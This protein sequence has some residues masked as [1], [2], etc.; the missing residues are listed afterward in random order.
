[1]QKEQE[2]KKQI[3]KSAESVKKKLKIMRDIS[4]SNDMVIESV[5]KPISEPLKKIAN[6]ND[7]QSGTETENFTPRKIKA[8]KWKFTPPK[9]IKKR[10]LSLSDS[11]DSYSDAPAN[12]Y[13]EETDEN[14]NGD[15]E[16]PDE[17][18]HNTSWSMSSE[19]FENIPFGVRRDKGKLFLG[20]SRLSV[21]ENNIL[22]AGHDY[23][24]TVGLMELLF[25]KTPNLNLITE[26][27]KNNYKSML[28]DTNVHRRDYDASKPIKSNKGIKYTQI[29][30]PLFKLSKKVECSGSENLEVQGTGLLKK[31]KQNVDYVYWDNP[32]E[33][34]ERLKLLWA[35]RDAGN[36]GVNNE[37]ISIMEELRESRII[38]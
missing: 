35:S 7:H 22:V 20:S 5:L 36:T 11:N 15:F 19:T 16:T 2:L 37:I 23:I 13:D 18:T 27:D 6:N 12:S 24:K 14:I 17:N 38:S 30:R 29:I 3:I 1:M 28:L 32:N 33:L 31:L 8:R 34:I 10:R 25:K 21:N 9:T 4:S 26:E